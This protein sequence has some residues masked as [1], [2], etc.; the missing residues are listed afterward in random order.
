MPPSSVV[1]FIS[2]CGCTI[3]TMTLSNTPSHVDRGC[4][5]L[6]QRGRSRRNGPSTAEGTA[7]TTARLTHIDLLRLMQR[8]HDPEVS[9]LG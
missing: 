4:G 7:S 2:H 8:R 9:V 6:L 5:R 3:R 1:R